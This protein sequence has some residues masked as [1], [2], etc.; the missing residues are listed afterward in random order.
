MEAKKNDIRAEPIG[1][2]DDDGRGDRSAVFVRTTTGEPLMTLRS[3]I[4]RHVWRKIPSDSITVVVG[5]ELGHGLVKKTITLAHWLKHSHLYA[6]YTGLESRVWSD[7]DVNVEVRYQT[8]LVPGGKNIG[9]SVN[10]AHTVSN[11]NPRNLIL[12]CTSAGTSL[13]Q[14]RVQPYLA[15]HH[16]VGL[17]GKITSMPFW[18]NSPDGL[19]FGVSGLGLGRECMVVQ[20]PVLMREEEKENLE[21]EK[22]VGPLSY[23][24]LCRSGFSR[25]ASQPISITVTTCRFTGPVPSPDVIQQEI[26]KLAILIGD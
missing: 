5:N 2:E 11:D 4:W 18:V 20:I 14:D 22:A 24:R 1:P 17:D 15:V 19:S 9:V 21:E 6:R 3:E 10:N 13:Q 8:V 23:T 12:F 7:T 16:I 25:D 26:E